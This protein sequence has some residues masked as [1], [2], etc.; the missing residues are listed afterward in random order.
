VALYSRKLK[1]SPILSY[2][3]GVSHVVATLSP[4][5][6]SYAVNVDATV[7]TAGGYVLCHAFAHSSSS[8]HNTSP[9]NL[10]VQ[11]DTRFY[12][13]VGMTGGMRIA[14]GSTIEVDCR[15][16]KSDFQV[17]NLAITATQ[18]NTIT[19]PDAPNHAARV[20][21]KPLNSFTKPLVPLTRADKVARRR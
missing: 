21:A 4:P 8:G 7:A 5:P 14:S 9:T 20:R 2:S 17:Q 10:A 16:S 3:A 1:S 13:T 6:G 18:V 19:Q 15:G 12:G 11:G